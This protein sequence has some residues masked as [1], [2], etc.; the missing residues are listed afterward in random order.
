MAIANNDATTPTHTGEG[1]INVLGGLDGSLAS[2]RYV[3][4]KLRSVVGVRVT[5]LA[6]GRVRC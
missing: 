5:A 6:P 1:A 4:F 2:A 3:P